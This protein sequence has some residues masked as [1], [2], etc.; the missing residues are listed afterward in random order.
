[1]KLI[2]QH[3]KKWIG[4]GSFQVLYL[5]K[6]VQKILDYISIL[7][8]HLSKSQSQCLNHPVLHSTFV[9]FWIA[10]QIYH[11]YEGIGHQI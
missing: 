7:L 3:F 8:V 10:M 6:R 9:A 11:M 4:V 2:S 5:H 1:M